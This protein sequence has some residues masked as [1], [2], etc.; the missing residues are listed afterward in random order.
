M[1]YKYEG[2]VANSLGKWAKRL[3]VQIKTESFDSVNLSSI[4]AFLLML[5]LECSKEGIQ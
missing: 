3:Q 2:R 4:I 1:S 5:K